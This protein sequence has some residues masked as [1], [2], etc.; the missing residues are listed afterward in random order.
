M[1]IGGITRE[2]EL[3]QKYQDTSRVA[4]LSDTSRERLAPEEMC[5]AVKKIFPDTVVTQR[6]YTLYPFFGRCKKICNCKCSRSSISSVGSS[7]SS[8]S[9]SSSMS[10]S[11]SGGINSSRWW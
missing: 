3:Y 6:S 2:D 5:E 7:S 9:S 1:C 4:Q 10:S 8:S 11:S